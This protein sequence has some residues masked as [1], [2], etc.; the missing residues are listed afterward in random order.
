MGT[1][2]ES[3]M[4]RKSTIILVLLL[5]ATGL[6]AMT[7]KW[8][9]PLSKRLEIMK[10]ARVEYLVN[11]TVKRVYDERNII[12]L[13]CTAKS[14]SASRVRG[15][16]AVFHRERGASLFRLRERYNAD[17]IIH[18]NGKF[19]VPPDQ[20]MP[21]LRNVPTF[22][23]GDL[24][25]G[26]TW[27]AP[28][29]LILSNF[30]APFKLLFP[31]QYTIT[32]VEKRD[33]SDVAVITYSFLIN[34]DLSGGRYPSDFPEK[35]YGQNTGRI[36][37]DL[38]RNSPV[39]I[40]DDYRIRFIFNNKVT[41]F[42]STEYR[43]TMNTGNRLYAG[44]SE[45]EKMRERD[46]IRKELPGN[47]GIK[48]DTHKRGIVLRLGEVFFDF[49]SSSLRKS[50]RKALDR[51]AGILA[52]KYPDREITVEGH[53]DNTGGKEYNRRL[54][55]ER[56]RAVGEYLKSRSGND[57]FSYRGFGPDRPITDNKSREAR[58]KNRRV[59]IIIKLN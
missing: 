52:E 39:D 49:D 10:T 47:S 22:P 11:N 21:N 38:A 28:A 17:F 5:S 55:V 44:V 14:D 26:D 36:R 18:K 20:Y 2:K 25:T 31:A 45:K 9:I 53:T 34:K 32:G 40:T 15:V 57:K 56:A 16:F 23:A 48:V 3:N 1:K 46:S 37:W 59:E 6:Q 13:T 50:S 41:G 30:S 29:E 42:G 43:M 4:K 12:D 27:S 54:S 51:L 35:I 58:E 7:L 8:D 24:K 33:G 19:H